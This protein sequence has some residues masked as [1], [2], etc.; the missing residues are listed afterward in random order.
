[1][2]IE[3]SVA[4]PG[5]WMPKQIIESGGMLAPTRYEVESR[6]SG[7]RLGLRNATSHDS[8]DRTFDAE[9]RDPY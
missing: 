3:D 9:G 6:I 1:L 2:L 8:R 5:V 4:K 7:W